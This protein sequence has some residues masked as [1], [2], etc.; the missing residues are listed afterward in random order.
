LLLPFSGSGIPRNLGVRKEE[1][2]TYFVTKVWTVG[3]GDP[4]DRGTEKLRNVDNL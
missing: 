1:E 2:G 4:E 3:I